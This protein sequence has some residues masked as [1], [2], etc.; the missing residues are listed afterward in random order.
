LIG[1]SR[2]SPAAL[3]SSQ[4]CPNPRVQLMQAE[5]SDKVVVGAEFECRYLPFLPIC[6][7][8]RNVRLTSDPSEQVE[9]V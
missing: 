9:L 4:H 1:I 8:E 7:D 5:G 3:E 6:D 2:P